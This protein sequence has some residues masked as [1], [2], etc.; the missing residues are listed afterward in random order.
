MKFFNKEITDKITYLSFLF[1]FFNILSCK[2]LVEVP[3]PIT[4][5]NAGN[6][7][8]SDASAASVLTGIYAKM[9]SGSFFTNGITTLSLYAGL[10]A[11]EL[12]LFPGSSN[13]TLIRYYQNG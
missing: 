9:S 13:T 11:D 1:I 4:G 7:Y 5:T 10:S 6:V 2:K 8:T 12:I 3:S